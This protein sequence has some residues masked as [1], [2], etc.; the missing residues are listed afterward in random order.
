[1]T[2]HV[3]GVFEGREWQW[4][5]F[6]AFHSVVVRSSDSC[7]GVDL[8]TGKRTVNITE[9]TT[10][11]TR[12]EQACAAVWRYRKPP[13]W[14]PCNSCPMDPANNSPSVVIDSHASLPEWHADQGDVQHD[15]RNG[16]LRVDHPGGL[17]RVCP[18][19]DGKPVLNN[20]TIIR[21][22]LGGDVLALL[23]LRNES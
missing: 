1:C 10:A 6:P 4:F 15:S 8:G 16:I 13:P 11:K 12:V 18:Q 19:A 14:L 22:Q 20:C 21:A 5:Y 3:L 9:A 2:A 17:V 23:T 7:Y